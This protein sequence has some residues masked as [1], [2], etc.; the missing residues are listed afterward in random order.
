MAGRGCRAGAG[1]HYWLGTIARPC[2]FSVEALRSGMHGWAAAPSLCLGGGPGIGI[3]VYVRYFSPNNLLG[4]D[5]HVK[6]SLYRGVTHSAWQSSQVGRAYLAGATYVTHAHMM[7]CL[8]I[9]QL[10]TQV[11]TVADTAS[12]VHHMHCVLP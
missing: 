11:N 12:Q 10:K 4:C 8:Q 7:Q 3:E 1:V 6:G 9:R 5:G 2:G